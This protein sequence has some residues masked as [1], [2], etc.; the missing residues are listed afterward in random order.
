[1]KKKFL[2]CFFTFF[3]CVVFSQ[4]NEDLATKAAQGDV[5]SQFLLG[6]RFLTGEG[7]DKNPERAFHRFY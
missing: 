4:S 3:S 7:T 5:R 6:Y 2:F 1:M